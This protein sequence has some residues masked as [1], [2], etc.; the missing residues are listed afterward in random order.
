M[1]NI[2]LFLLLVLFAG[3]CQNNPARTAIK[4]CRNTFVVSGF[5][6]IY[7]FEHEKER[8]D[9]SLIR[10]FKNY[11]NSQASYYCGSDYLVSSFA[12]KGADQNQGGL[13]LF[14]VATGASEDIDI[15]EN[16]EGF[17]RYKNGILLETRLLQGQPIDPT[18]GYLTP[19]ELQN[20]IDPG[21]GMGMGEPFHLFTYLHFFDL[22]QKRITRSYREGSTFQRWI[23]GDTMI[24]LQKGAF[25]K[26]DLATGR[27]EP[28]YEVGAK[29]LPSGVAALVGEQ[30]YY[31]TGPHSWNAGEDRHHKRLVGY[32]H[33]AIYKLVNGEFVKEF[34]IP[35][36]DPVYI[37]TPNERDI[38]VFTQESRKVIRY[39][40]VTKRAAEYDF[41]NQGKSIEAVGYTD[42][43]LV[44]VTQ[45]RPGYIGGAVI[46][47][48]QD[49]SDVSKPYDLP[50]LNTNTVGVSSNR[51]ENVE[52]RNRLR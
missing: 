49:F 32:E 8:S 45:T 18:L 20:R 36:P 39:D 12:F 3:G 22:E 47:A 2:Y 23:R 31:V 28:L 35:Y 13:S 15:K 9:F 16:A 17:I 46:V 44:I 30:L 42:T 25:V 37:A 11:S 34:A 1:K 41:D 52:Y 10:S 4:D 27:R 48:T 43:H 33:N 38:Y 6:T 21:R 19:G 50:E 29:G 40:T 5:D 26:I 14:N 51:Y 24:A 7:L